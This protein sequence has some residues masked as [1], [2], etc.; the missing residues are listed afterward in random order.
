MIL[1]KS[2]EYLSARPS[3][4][5]FAFIKFR[6]GTHRLKVETDRRLLMILPIG[7]RICCHRNMNAA[8]DE[9]H[10]LFHCPFWQQHTV[11]F[12]S[13][14]GSIRLFLG[15]IRP[16][17]S[18]CSCMYQLFHVKAASLLFSELSFCPVFGLKSQARMSH[19]AQT[20]TVL[21]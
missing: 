5:L 15:S 21:D 8:E 3:P 14:Q 13:D 16:S 17:Y 6:L 7:P 20:R 4:A 10:Y 2:A 1:I 12:G 18:L 9:Q 11:L 19:L